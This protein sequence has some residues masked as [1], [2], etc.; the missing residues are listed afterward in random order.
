MTAMAILHWFISQSLFFASVS[1]FD[2][3]YVLDKSKTVK[4]L[5]WSP[6]AVL[7]G[8]ILWLLTILALPTLR[9]QKYPTGM[10]LA[11]SNSAVISDACHPE[12]RA[13]IT[14]RP[15]KYDV[16]R[17]TDTEAGDALDSRR[18]WWNLL[19]QARYMSDLTGSEADRY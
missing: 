3:N 17:S 9:F 11:G 1:V 6:L 15:L 12:E 14:E 5:R 10:P 2:Y 7:L 19:F 4:N 8:L 16:L 18:R 13:D